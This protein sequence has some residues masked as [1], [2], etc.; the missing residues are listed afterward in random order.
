M[1][2]VPTQSTP[3]TTSFEWPAPQTMYSPFKR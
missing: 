2:N 1:H 3:L